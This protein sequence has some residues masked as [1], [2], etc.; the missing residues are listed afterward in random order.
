MVAGILRFLFFFCSTCGS[1]V[2]LDRVV[3][4]SPHNRALCLRIGESVLNSCP[5]SE[6]YSR[7]NVGSRSI[8]LSG[9]KKIKHQLAIR[10]RPL[11]TVGSL[12]LAAA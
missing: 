8:A 5:L 12:A 7:S 1:I 11:H 2:G 10:K 4:S 3:C 9:C 6:F